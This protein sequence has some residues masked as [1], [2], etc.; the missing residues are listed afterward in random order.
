MCSSCFPHVSAIS[1]GHRFS[2]ECIMNMIRSIVLGGHSSFFLV[3]ISFDGSD[4]AV[5][6]SIIWNCPGCQPQIGRV[7]AVSH[8]DDSSACDTPMEARLRLYSAYV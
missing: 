6:I 4:C 2:G 1:I 7:S 8:H 3:L 5:A